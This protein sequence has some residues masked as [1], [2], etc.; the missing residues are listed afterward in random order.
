MSAPIAKIQAT[1]PEVFVTVTRRE[2][3]F[4]IPAIYAARAG[5]QA[6]NALTF[7]LDFSV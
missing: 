1:A 2:G 4:A 6:V 5:N 3:N 7:G